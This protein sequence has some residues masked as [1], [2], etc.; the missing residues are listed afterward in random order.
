MKIVFRIYAA[1]V[2]TILFPSIITAQLPADNLHTSSEKVGIN[3]SLD[4]NSEVFSNLV[5]GRTN[6]TAFQGF[7]NLGVSLDL[8]KLIGFENTS[9]DFNVINLHGKSPSAFVGDDLLVS[10]MDGAKTTRV[11]QLFIHYQ[12]SNGKLGIKT[13]QLAV[14][15]DFLST[16]GSSLFLHMPAAYSFTLSPNSP[17]WPV[18][19]TALQI[20]YSLTDQWTIRLAGFD[21]DADNLDEFDANSSGFS[22]TLQPDNAFI[23]AE[24]S[25]EGS[26]LG[27]AGFYRFGSWH[28][29]NTF[30]T[31]GG[32]LEQ[33]LTS[34]YL[35]ADQQVLASTSDESDGLY[36]FALAGWIIQDD[37]APY[38]YDIHAGIYWKG[39][40]SKYEDSLGF[41]IT[42]PHVGD[43]VV[44]SNLPS[45]TQTESFLEWTY[46]TTISETWS[47]QGSVQHVINPGGASASQ[48]EN[49]T[50]IG[51][52][53]TLS[54]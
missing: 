6:K 33:G 23:I 12:T 43:V 13:G 45:Q 52:R 25:F 28:D 46:Q 22:F 36:L 40:S 16:E 48:L 51:I 4:Y 31:A 11:Q 35:A 32:T 5:G 20:R 18:A 39:I 34:I 26:F 17:P 37:R 3:W 1:I 29:T 49:A 8:K 53:S 9:I 27:G 10:N 41:I 47:I 38:D 7:L 21:A 50:V 14:D 42:Y 19:S 44:A 24:A 54:F 30:S 15:E 2:I